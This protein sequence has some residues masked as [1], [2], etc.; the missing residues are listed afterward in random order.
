VA[1]YVVY[2]PQDT[3]GRLLESMGFR[4][5]AGLARVTGT[6]SGANLSRERTDLPGTPGIRAS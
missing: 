6:E 2:G 3:R 4:L 5:P 1:S